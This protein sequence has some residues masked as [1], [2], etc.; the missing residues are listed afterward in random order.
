M[1]ERDSG[2]LPEFVNRPLTRRQVLQGALVLGAGAALGPVIAGCGSS[3]SGTGSSSTSATPVASAT[4][5]MGGQLRVAAG[6][7]S[8]KETLDA[9]AAAMTMQSMDMRFNLYD[10]LCEYSPTGVH[11]MAL[12]DEIVPNATGTQ[13]TVRLKPGLCSATARRSTQT[14]SCTASIES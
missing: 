9:H 3:G 7:G 10:S 1:G 8:A 12:A 11:G 2:F 13:Y 14:R 5:K 4:P 6:L